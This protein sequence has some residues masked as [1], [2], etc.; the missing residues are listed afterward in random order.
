MEQNIFALDPGGL[1]FLNF[2]FGVILPQCKQFFFHQILLSIISYKM[3]Y[4]MIMVI[5]K[6]HNNSNKY[7][8]SSHSTLWEQFPTYLYT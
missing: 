3:Y 5:D 8:V 6:G 7:I 2:D 4:H 1:F